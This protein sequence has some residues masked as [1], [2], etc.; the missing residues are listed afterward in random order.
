[1]R[2]ASTILKTSRCAV[3]RHPD[4]L[5][6]EMLR[7]AGMSLESVA[8]KFE[9][10]SGGRD[11]LWRHMKNHVTEDE[12]A[13]MLADVPI[14]E[15]AA[16]AAEEGIALIDY[17]ALIRSSLLQQVRLA[18]T[19]NDRHGLAAVSGKALDCLREIGKLTGE[20]KDI[21]SRSVTV[22]QQF[23]FLAS[24]AFAELQQTLIRALQPYPQALAAVVGALQ[25]IEAT[26]DPEAYKA[27]A[28]PKGEYHAQ[29]V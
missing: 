5:R 18:A 7:L 2:K 14:A 10:G 21:G 11:S 19:V 1:M 12:K 23:N 29:A 27:I 17:L 9:L 15:A 3:C 6:I 24:P 4:R 28:L 8:E 22:N 25:E 26:P 13:V 16:R 20:L